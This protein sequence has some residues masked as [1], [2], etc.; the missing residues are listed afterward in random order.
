MNPIQPVT[1]KKVPYS[2][3]ELGSLWYVRLGFVHRQHVDQKHRNDD[4]LPSVPGMT[5]L[6]FDQ[7]EFLRAAA[8]LVLGWLAAANHR[9]VFLGLATWIDCKFGHPG[10]VL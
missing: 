4:V 9:A 8:N 7:R 3:V 10:F 5:A 1:P 2:P 6:A